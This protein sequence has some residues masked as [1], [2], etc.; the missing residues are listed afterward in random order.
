[1]FNSNPCRRGWHSHLTISIYCM[2]IKR[3]ILQLRLLQGYV[4]FLTTHFLSTTINFR[5]TANTESSWATT[6]TSTH[7]VT[8]LELLGAHTRAGVSTNHH[9]AFILSY[10]FLSSLLPCLLQG[11][12][13]QQTPQQ[14]PC[15]PLLP[16]PWD[17]RPT[18]PSQL[19]LLPLHILSQVTGGAHSTGWWPPIQAETPLFLGKASWI[20]SPHTHQVRHSWIFVHPET[21]WSF[22]SYHKALRHQTQPCWQLRH[23][24]VW[25]V[26][27]GQPA[28]LSAVN[29][30]LLPSK[31][32][33]TDWVILNM[34][35][36]RRSL[37]TK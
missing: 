6:C 37:A 27:V 23:E 2:L 30:V 25:T 16:I 17:L 34:Y 10:R 35:L 32:V 12:Y 4:G 14:P 13:G 9:A 26:H 5:G 36:S 1:M 8:P 11:A 7:P 28:S 33:S 19:G 24:S 21:A 15:C 3:L 22:T 18:S 31:L 29:L 20:F